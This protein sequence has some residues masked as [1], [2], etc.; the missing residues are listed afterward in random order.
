[1]TTPTDTAHAAPA[2]VRG[3]FTIRTKYLPPTDTKGGRVKAWRVDRCRNTGKTESV[4]RSFHATEGDAHDYAL[5]EWFDIH[6]RGLGVKQV[7]RGSVEGGHTYT[8]AFID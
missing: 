4:T 6:G 1:M 2:I 7:I 5:A 8:V 3:G